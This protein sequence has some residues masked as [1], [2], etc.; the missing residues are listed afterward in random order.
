MKP[1]SYV[2]ECNRIPGHNKHIQ[3]WEE[4]LEQQDRVVGWVV[5]RPCPSRDLNEGKE[6]SM[7]RSGRRARAGETACAK[8][9]GRKCSRQGG[10]D[11]W[12]GQIERKKEGMTWR[13]GESGSRPGNQSKNFIFYF[14]Y[15]LYRFTMFCQLLLYSKV[16]ELYIHIHSFSH[17]IF[18]HVSSQVIG[19]SSLCYTAGPHFLVQ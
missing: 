1:K 7:H 9:L 11:G 18:H 8:A 2:I 10:Q 4:G 17:M 14:I 15:I 12:C 19:Y 6:Q 5:V 13:G 3:S 16:T